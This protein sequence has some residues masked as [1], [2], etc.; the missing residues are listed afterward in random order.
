MSKWRIERDCEGNRGKDSVVQQEEVGTYL[1]TSGVFGM[2]R[3]G[4]SPVAAFIGM[5]F[6]GLGFFDN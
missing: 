1:T 2:V 4:P 3:H 5:A 6:I